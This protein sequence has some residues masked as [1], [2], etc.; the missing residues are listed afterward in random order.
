M[1]IEC[2]LMTKRGIIAIILIPVSVSTQ[3]SKIIFVKSVDKTSA[4]IGDTSLIQ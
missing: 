3:L 2:V 4:N 1:N